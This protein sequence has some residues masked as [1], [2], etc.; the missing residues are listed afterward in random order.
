MLLR[1]YFN[2]LNFYKNGELSRNQIGRSGVQVKKENEKF[3]A[4]R[5]R[6]P[7][8]LKCCHFTLLFCRERQEMYQNVKRT[9]SSLIGSLTATATKTSPENITL[10]HL[11]YFAIISTRST[12]TET[13]NYPGTKLV[14]V[15]SK[16]RK[17]KK[18]EIYTVVCSRSPKRLEFGHFTLLFCRGQQRN[19]P[20]CKTHVQSDCF[21]H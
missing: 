6:S 2:S 21:A 20:K 3:T 12:S 15:A 17:K 9:C 5:S 14:G 7:Q 10:F 18:N 19:V 11:C 8:N 13:A 1:D 4:V 16:L